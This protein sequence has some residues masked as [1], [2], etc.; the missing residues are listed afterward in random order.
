M[1]QSKLTPKPPP[2]IPTT[3]TMESG[4]KPLL[5][6]NDNQ[7]PPE[8]KP[9]QGQ[10]TESTAPEIKANTAELGLDKDPNLGTSDLKKP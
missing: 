7:K 6:G 10:I 4:E 1:S 5:S 2:S 8:E 3:K 9:S